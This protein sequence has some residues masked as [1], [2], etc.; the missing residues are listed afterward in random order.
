LKVLDHTRRVVCLVR[1]IGQIYLRSSFSVAFP[2]EPLF[3]PEDVEFY[4]PNPLVVPLVSQR[5]IGAT[6][7]RRFCNRADRL[8]G[9]SLP[10]TVAPAPLRSRETIMTS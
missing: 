8:R 7:T 10:H 2:D 6:R 1:L 9:G 3:V 5:R 4:E